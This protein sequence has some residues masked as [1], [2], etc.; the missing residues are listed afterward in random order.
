MTDK[1]QEKTGS[2]TFFADWMKMTTE[3]WNPMAWMWSVFTNS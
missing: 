1:S 2:E 3:L